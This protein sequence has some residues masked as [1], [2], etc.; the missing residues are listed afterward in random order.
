MLNRACADLAGW[1]HCPKVTVKVS[2]AW[3][4]RHGFAQRVARAL[5]DAG[6]RAD[7][8]ELAVD[9][10]ALLE[11]PQQILVALNDVCAL[12]VRVSMD[13]FG[14]TYSMVL[15]GLRGAPFDKVK[16]AH[17]IVRNVGLTSESDA[18]RR[19]VAKLCGSFGIM[20][21]A[22][23][24]DEAHQLAPLTT[25]NCIEVQGRLFGGFMTASE[26]AAFS[27]AMRVPQTG[28]I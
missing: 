19:A 4:R 3:I 2:A 20:I 21:A 24:V 1:P 25:D 27:T 10:S 22:R 17:A 26:V 28:S 8:L 18:V 12:G 6:I 11:D 15:G 16:F 14:S 7:R 23:G 5:A 9:E 13:N